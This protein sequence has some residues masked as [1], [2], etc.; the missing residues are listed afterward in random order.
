MCD[1]GAVYTE[2]I[3]WLELRALLMIV[4]ESYFNDY[5]EKQVEVLKNLRRFI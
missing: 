5:S 2:N 3:T 4:G 1:S